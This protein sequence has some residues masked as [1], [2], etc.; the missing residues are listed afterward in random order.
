[1]RFFSFPPKKCKLVAYVFPLRLALSLKKK[2]KEKEI[3]IFVR[4]ACCIQLLYGSLCVHSTEER[5]KDH[6]RRSELSSISWDLN[7]LPRRWGMWRC[8][9]GE[10][11]REGDFATICSYSAQ[12]RPRVPT[13]FPWIH[14]CLL[15]TVVLACALS[16]LFL[17]STARSYRLLACGFLRQ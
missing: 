13:R 15:D 7:A 1:M 12:L 5:K 3:A 2:K 6:P 4:A 8:T 9:L 10:A 17:C 16:S 14:R 11:L